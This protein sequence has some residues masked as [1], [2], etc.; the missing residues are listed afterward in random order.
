MSCSDKHI[1]WISDPTILYKNNKFLEFVPT[2]KMDR[3]SQLNA[4]TRFAIYFVILALIMDK[5]IIWV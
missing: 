1:F 3:V 4:I 2:N 5:P